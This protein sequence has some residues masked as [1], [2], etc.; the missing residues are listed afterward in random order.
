MAMAFNIDH[1]MHY[2]IGALWSVGFVHTCFTHSDY[3]VVQCWVHTA[4]LS[5]DTIN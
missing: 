2:H 4:Y 1:V 3:L 5:A